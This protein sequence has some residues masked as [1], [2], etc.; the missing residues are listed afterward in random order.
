MQGFIIIIIIFYQTRLSP[1]YKVFILT[2]ELRHLWM[3]DYWNKLNLHRMV[4][5][6]KLI[7][8]LKQ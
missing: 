7:S 6:Y 4:F 3:T 1:S 8:H 5:L 2:L